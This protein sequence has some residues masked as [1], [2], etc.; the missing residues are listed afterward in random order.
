MRE[1]TSVSPKNTRGAIELKNHTNNKMKFLV[2]NGNCSPL[3]VRACDKS[4][5]LTKKYSLSK[6]EH[7]IL[8]CVHILYFIYEHD[9]NVNSNII[10]NIP[11]DAASG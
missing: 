3:S 11:E 6:T 1:I 5:R 8:G 10:S 7:T 2:L 4:H 9:I